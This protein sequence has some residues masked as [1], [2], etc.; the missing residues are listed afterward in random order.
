M[1][2]GILRK[3]IT[4]TLP[5]WM[6]DFISQW[7]EGFETVEQRMRFVIAC[8]LKS[9][10]SN[11]GGPFAAA[12]FDQTSHALVAAGVNLVTTQCCSSAHA[13]IVA[14]SFAQQ[15]LGR[16]DISDGGK[17]HYELV[18]ST[19][20]CAMC[21]GAVPWSGVTRLVCGARD[22]D[23]RA[24]GFDEGAK[25]TDWVAQLNRRGI[26]VITDVCREEAA[27]VLRSYASLGGVI[28]NSRN[29]F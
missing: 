25:V 4:I 14:L 7:T 5:A 24:V 1:T 2:P 13:E 29:S 28:Y 12:V 22:E 10:S 27:S 20:P 21:L 9:V 8:A 6:D 16:F 23:A 11:S 18:T 15:N 17:L 3:S 26:E 19:A